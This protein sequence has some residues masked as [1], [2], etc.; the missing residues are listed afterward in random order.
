MRDRFSPAL[1]SLW[2]SSD[3]QKEFPFWPIL[4]MMPTFHLQPT[5]TRYLEPLIL[6]TGC[7]IKAL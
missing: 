1:S 6:G 7:L 3:L 5:R 2:I 4:I